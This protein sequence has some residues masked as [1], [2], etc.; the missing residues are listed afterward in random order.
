[1]NGDKSKIT[2]N[3]QCRFRKKKKIIIVSVSNYEHFN[4]KLVIFISEQTNSDFSFILW[5]PYVCKYLCNS[6]ASSL[7]HKRKFLLYGLRRI[8]CLPV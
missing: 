4:E 2:L 7:S 1:M 6:S 3:I 5:Q 8:G